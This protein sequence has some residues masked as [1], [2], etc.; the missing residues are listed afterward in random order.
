MNN[1]WGSF[2]NC[3]GQKIIWFF[4]KYFRVR[5]DKLNRIKVNKSQKE[6]GKYIFFM[7]GKKVFFRAKNSSV[8]TWWSGL[9]ICFLF[10]GWIFPKKSMKIFFIETTNLGFHSNFL[11]KK[12]KVE[13]EKNKIIKPL[14]IFFFIWNY[15]DLKP[16][17]L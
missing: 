10:C 17:L 8:N 12:R 4:W 6:F 16:R 14:E 3:Y 11:Y 9:D 2:L 13:F 5:T 1:F 15:K 7:G